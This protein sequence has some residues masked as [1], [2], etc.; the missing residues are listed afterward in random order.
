MAKERRARKRHSSMMEI[1]EQATMDVKE[2][3]PAPARPITPGL[4]FIEDTYNAIDEID[5]D[6]I[7]D[8]GV[9][10]RLEKFTA[11]NSG[12]D[13]DTDIPNHS[14]EQLADSIR[15]NGQQ[16]PI[17]VR[18]EPGRTGRYQIIYGRRRLAACRYLKENYPDE[19]IKIKA[20]VVDLDDDKALIA[21]ALEN[22]SRK[23]LTFYERA[24]FATDII[25]SGKSRS[26]VITIMS[27]TKSGLSNLERVTKSIPR[28]LGDAIGAAP[29]F[30]RT[31]W[32]ILVDA[33]DQKV[34]T[35]RNAF[36]ELEKLPP[37]SSSDERLLAL[38]DE[39]KRKSE[40]PRPNPRIV[41]EGLATVKQGASGL[42][43]SINDSVAP[44]FSDW[45]DEHIESL[46]KEFRDRFEAVSGRK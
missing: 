7:D 23:D 5:P 13:E 12:A 19:N 33:L 8:W 38:L 3:A 24:R 32:M 41:G 21:K 25:A 35:L 10:D 34:I 42:N 20:N 11:V 29:G 45:L 26:E 14:L 15:E 43:I 31:K 37:D 22:A 27:L 17:Q 28:E 30:G 39:I 46:M 2:A 4:Q 1:A 40:T 36:R 16:V 9:E 18:H 6:L 44:G